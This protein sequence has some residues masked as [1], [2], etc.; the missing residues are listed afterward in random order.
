MF[1]LGKGWVINFKQVLNKGYL[2]L[3]NKNIYLSKEHINA[4]NI[5]DCD[6][7]IQ[8]LKEEDI[9]KNIE[10]IQNILLKIG[11]KVLFISHF[12]LMNEIPNREL[13]INCLISFLNNS[14][15]VNIIEINPIVF[16]NK[17]EIKDPIIG[18]KISENRL[19]IC[20]KPK[21]KKIIDII[22]LIGM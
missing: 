13:I 7:D 6:Y 11:K 17:F 14:L 3:R 21:F 18:I 9:L 15:N 5:N 2:Q 22:K 19:L 1:C 20:N 10:N 12:N 16:K 4:I 8:N